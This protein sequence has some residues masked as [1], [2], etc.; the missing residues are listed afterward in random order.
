MSKKLLIATLF[1]CVII[2]SISYCVYSFKLKFSA[3]SEAQISNSF[4]TNGKNLVFPKCLEM[5]QTAQ[6]KILFYIDG[7]HCPTCLL[8][9]ISDVYGA[10][11]DSID[12]FSPLLI[13]HPSETV[14]T[15]LVHNFISQTKS[16]LNVVVCN[17]DSIRAYNEWMSPD[18]NFYGMV[19]D[20]VNNIQYAGFLFSPNFPKAAI[21]ICNGQ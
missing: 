16:W 15:V 6:Y 2:F 14:D 4:I 20:S 12:D 1:I 9:N 13:Y 21:H 11:E 10:M 5:N 7:D 18:V 3:L 17:D 19:L 8:T